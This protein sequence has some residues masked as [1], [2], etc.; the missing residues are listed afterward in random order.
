[1]I[2]L[3]PCKDAF[4]QSTHSISESVSLLSEKVK[5]DTIGAFFHCGITGKV[6]PEI[7]VLRNF[8]FWFPHSLLFKGSFSIKNKQAFLSGKFEV[9]KS[10]RIFMN[11]LLICMALL[12]LFP[13]VFS[14]GASIRYDFWAIPLVILLLWFANYLLYWSLWKTDIQY[15][16]KTIND[17]LL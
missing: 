16:S 15:I 5:R 11:F 8:R 13:F 4:F 2:S 14:H 9:T 7:V 3:Y 17:T 6:T 10:T 12:F 1:M